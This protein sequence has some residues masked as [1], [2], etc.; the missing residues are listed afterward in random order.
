MLFRSAEPSRA[1]CEKYLAVAHHIAVH[2]VMADAQNVQRASSEAAG[3]NRLNLGPGSFIL[4][5]I[6]D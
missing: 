5:Y 6:Y 4:S 2:Q 1:C 3:K